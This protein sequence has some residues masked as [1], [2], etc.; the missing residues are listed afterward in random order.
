MN[1]VAAGQPELLLTAVQPC[2]ALEKEGRGQAD[3]RARPPP[4]WHCAVCDNPSQVQRCRQRPAQSTAAP[5]AGPPPPLGSLPAQTLERQ[6][7]LCR[8]RV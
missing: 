6:N 3:G 1:A 2:G 4:T 8:A 7:L 5:A